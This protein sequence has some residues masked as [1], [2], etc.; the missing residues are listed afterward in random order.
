MKRLLRIA[1]LL[2]FPLFADA[3]TDVI[4]SMNTDAFWKGIVF[5][6]Y[7]A[8]YAQGK[9]GSLPIADTLFMVA[10]NRAIQFSKPR[11]MSEDR[12]ENH[13]N[14][15]LVFLRNGQWNVWHTSFKTAM[16]AMQRNNRDRD[17]VVYTEGFGKIF[18]TGIYRG[19][20]MAS[21]Y[22]V[23]VLYLDYPSYNTSKKLMGNYYF[24]LDNARQSGEDFA[25]V[26]DTLK[27]YR[28]A[29]KMG[30]GKLTLFFHSMGN[31]MIR[32]MVRNDKI[33][34]INKE[35]W[36]D[37]LVLNSACVPQ[38]NHAQWVDQINFANRIYIN[39]NPKDA[40]LSG[41]NFM[42]LKKQLG[43][44]QYSGQS[45]KAIYVNFNS[46]CNRNHS[47]FLTLLAHKPTAPAAIAYYDI[48]FHG[49]CVTLEDG[50]CFRPNAEHK[51]DYTILDAMPQPV[52]EATKCTTCKKGRGID[53]GKTSAANGVAEGGSS[54]T[55][56]H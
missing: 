49:N 42:S 55:M 23:N 7:K 54:S 37:N 28:Q 27:R 32:E 44:R 11:F 24:A 8:E 46:L 18:T 13:L 15:F 22:K 10:S 31:N 36:V 34:S 12:G 45:A 41:A 21:Q 43:Q 16:L 26:F 33:G 3:K 50:R 20:S 4:D 29:G 5:K 39:Y 2:L 14:Y 51:A 1:L 35:Q 25:P 38:K 40:T 17:W 9:Q 53:K 56:L 6:D 52:E 47:N 19:I 30:D 48:L